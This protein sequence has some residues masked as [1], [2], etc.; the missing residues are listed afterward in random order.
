MNAKDINIRMIQWNKTVKS[1]LLIFCFSLLFSSCDE[2]KFLK[3][4][5]VDFYSPENSYITST[6]Y[7]AAIMNLY[8][9]VRD[10]FFSS[11]NANDFPSAAIEATDV[12]YQHKDLGFTVDMGTVLLSTS[13]PVYRALWEPAYRIIYDA[14]AIIERSASDENE[15]TTE[16]KI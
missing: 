9:S 13:T 4:E 16:E 2:E 3:T 10:E 8:A 15:L 11:D 6:N 14:N 7:E 5:P 12:C 1:I